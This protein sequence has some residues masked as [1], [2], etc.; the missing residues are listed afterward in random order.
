MSKTLFVTNIGQL[1]TFRSGTGPRR[2]KDMR[3]LDIIEN[4]GLIA[5][6]GKIAALGP[7]K[8]MEENPLTDNAETV[9][10][11]RGVVLPGFCDSHTHPAFMSA[12]IKDFALRTAGASYAE[13]KAQGGG[14]MASVADVRQAT[15]EALKRKVIDRSEK[16]LMSGTTSI[17]A[18]SGYGLSKESE[19]KSLRAIVSASKECP[20]TIVPTLLAAHSVPPEFADAE[21][22]ARHI[23]TEIIPAVAAEKLA[24]FVDVFCEKDFFTPEQAGFISKAA[25]SYGLRTKVHAEQLTH[26]G[27]IAAAAKARAISADHVDYA[28]GADMELMKE[29]GVIPV[30]L[31]ASNHFLG[32]SKF[33]PAREM[34]DCGLPVALATDFNPGT[35]P[36]WNMQFVMSLACTHMKMTPEEALCA[37]TV[38]GAYAMGLGE[39]AGRLATGLPADFAVMDTDDYRELCY[40]FGDNICAMT[41]KK[42]EIAYMSE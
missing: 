28:D 11:G 4:A 39:S 6:N 36:C 15:Q 5:H 29:S 17:E 23:A 34:I 38:N 40:Y 31:P 18:K 3:E 37:A 42:G 9:D 7:V 25:F 22:Y 30:L 1:V 19:L 8:E 14:I 33:P 32:L 20:L 13:I 26:S 10:V 21:S 41:V 2:G 16:F 27:G 12:R 35:S 24:V